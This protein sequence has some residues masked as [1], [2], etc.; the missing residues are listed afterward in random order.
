MATTTFA[1]RQFFA[2]PNEFTGSGA[3]V[4]TGTFLVTGSA[5]NLIINGTRGNTV[6]LATDEPY[7]GYP[8]LSDYGWWAGPDTSMD[9]MLDAKGWG[10]IVGGNGNYTGIKGADNR[11]SYVSMWGFQGL[12]G[13]QGDYN[14]AFISLASNI[15]GTAMATTASC[16]TWLRDNGYYYQYPE[17]LDGQSPNTGTGSDTV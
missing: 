12:Q 13:D 17:G 9:Y 11:D 6:Q 16:K 8:A 14:A 3:E 15:R 2:I 5:S 7:P 1:V 10:I 4:P